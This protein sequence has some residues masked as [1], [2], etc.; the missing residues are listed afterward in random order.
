M[1]KK[2][3]IECHKK[4]RIL[5]WM[6]IPLLFT[7]CL[8]LCATLSANARLSDPRKVLHGVV[9]GVDGKPLAGVTVI[10]KGT[11][12][13]TAT[14]SDGKFS[15]PEDGKILVFSFIGMKSKELPIAGKANF[16]V[17]L[18]EESL[19]LDDVVIVGY[20]TQKKVTVTG[21]V[22]SVGTDQLLAA[23]V[24]NISNSLGG[25]IPG[26][27]VLQSTGSPGNDQTTLRIRGVGTFSGSQDP[28][29]L[30][31]G[32][33][34]TNFDSIDPSEVESVTVLK[35]ASATA[36]Y[37]VRGANGV[38]LVTSKRGKLGKP[39]I[40]L[41][42]NVAVN[43]ISPGSIRA[44]ADAYDYANFYQTQ[45]MYD[46]YISGTYT[47]AF[48][49][50]DL[51]LYKNGTDPIWHPNVNWLKVI[52]KPV[53]FQQQHNLNIRGGTEKVK[54]FVSVGYFDQG[55]LF[56]N[57]NLV[58]DFFDMQSRFKRYNLRANFDFE[59]TKR[60]SFTVNLSTQFEE[61]DGSAQTPE[62]M[63]RN[64][65]MSNPIGSPALVNGQLV[66]FATAPYGNAYPLSG[67]YT[68]GYQKSYSNYLDCLIRANY[69]LDF[70]TKGLSAHGTIS[71]K[72]FNNQTLLFTKVSLANIYNP[73]RTASGSTVLVTNAPEQ[74]T[75]VSMPIGTTPNT[76]NG[77]ARTVY[78][79]LALDYSKTF[80]DHNLTGLL[81]YNQSKLFDPTLQFDISSGY[82]GLI[83]R[84]AYDYKSRYLAE[85]DFGYNGTENFA[86]G[87]RFG[88]FPAYSIGWIL[89]EE[90][91]FPKNGIVSFMKFR[92]SYG[93]VG[94]D[95]I[96]G[97]RFLYRPN[98]YTYYSAAYHFGNVGSTISP[99]QG[100]TEG[101]IGNPDLTWERAKKTDIGV[102]LTLFNGK[103]KISADIFR[104]MRDNILTIPNTIP[105]IFGGGTNLPTVNIGKMK[106]QGY[107]GE[108]TYYGKAGDF[109]Y[110]IGA[111]YT[112]A[113]NT[114][115]YRDEVYNPYSYLYTTGQ[116]NGQLFGGVANGFY[117]S[118]TDVNDA[119]RPK[120]TYV[121]N[122]IQPGDQNIRDINGDGVIDVNDK[123]PI[124][125]TEFPEI[126]FGL[127]GALSYKKFDF[128]FLFQGVTHYTF[129]AR[130]SYAVA[131][132]GW[133]DAPQY[134]VDNSWTLQKYQSGG[135]ITFPRPYNASARAINFDFY[136]TVYSA[137]GS[138][139][140]LRSAEI[141]YTLDKV[142]LLKRLGIS[143]A[144]VYISGS[145]LFTFAP[146]MRKKFPGVDPENAGSGVS[147]TS[148]EPYPRPRVF[149]FGFNLNF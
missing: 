8:S 9:K 108:I 85:F 13:G 47:P 60:L 27:L 59:V 132:L 46:S 73:L 37:G 38:I 128:N 26:L 49:A 92:G 93:E 30:V 139:V 113:R 116:R 12:K 65:Y 134:M 4:N 87:K 138:Y 123:A 35:D 129:D 6:S 127:N 109:N 112:Y 64:M 5:Q 115:L 133:S 118:W 51:Q 78:T 15:L 54:Y 19:G 56:N 146:D 119:Y 69:K 24:A 143:S 125:Y 102:E 40:S 67:M 7:I 88:F 148:T 111:N 104:E 86:P 94:N 68:A 82:Q 22:S 141:G 62:A 71:Y 84:A 11:L 58:P 130:G 106:N 95:K 120:N 149:N 63:I 44:R 137:D 31:D 140:K 79:E 145:N 99:Y 103:V 10:I 77:K 110:K 55:G 42:S 53:S 2:V 90:P 61:R 52:F 18:E 36:V 91:F 16:N 101:K 80:G 66:N 74:P 114:V 105:W 72:N 50:T 81:L 32:I 76:S 34:S 97:S 121:N 100:A 39:Q 75:S 43:T 21:A 126:V 57:T 117:N 48:T 20:G 144:R 135:L 83:G 23:P 70:I 89:S 1:D 17:V 96:G 33:E 131:A 25:R 28:L 142:S 14:D 29:I 147:L 124:G 41:T 107:D 45:L 3:I 98:S 136:S 122:R